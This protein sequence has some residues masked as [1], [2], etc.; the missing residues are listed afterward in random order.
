MIVPVGEQMQEAGYSFDS[1]PFIADREVVE[2]PLRPLLEGAV[3][4]LDVV[5]YSKRLLNVIQFQRSER[6]FVPRGMVRD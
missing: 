4:S 2:E 5:P 6:I 1:S 3:P